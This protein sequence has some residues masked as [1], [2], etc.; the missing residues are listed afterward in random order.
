MEQIRQLL[1][2]LLSA[3]PG[4]IDASI[5]ARLQQA[6]DEQSFAEVRKIIDDCRK[7]VAERIRAARRNPRLKHIARM[8]LIGVYTGTRPGAML[9][10]R[11]VPSTDGGW[12]DLDSETLHRK[13]I[14]RVETKKRQPKARIHARLLPHLMRWRKMDME[15]GVKRRV[16]SNRRQIKVT[17]PCTYVIQYYGKPVEKRRR[18]WA[19]AAIKAGYAN[20]DKKGKWVIPDGPHVYRHTAATWQMQP[21]P[22]LTRRRGISAC[23]WSRCLRS[24]GTTT[25][26][27]RAGRSRPRGSAT[28]ML[29]Q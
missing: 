16:T 9:K 4:E 22:I 20:K 5:R 1:Y 6:L 14:G 26:T 13:G 29:R 21:A 3:P 24:T 7:Q 17:E 10:L 8:L 19:Q 25:P 18:L 11:W 27:S 2:T 28:A 23:R 12:F 15:V